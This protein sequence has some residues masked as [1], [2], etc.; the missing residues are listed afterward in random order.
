MGLRPD[1]Y[2]AA[3]LHTLSLRVAGVGA[4]TSVQVLYGA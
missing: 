1:L 4:G 2:P 3:W